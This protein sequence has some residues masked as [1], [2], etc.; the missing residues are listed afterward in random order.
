M[1]IA[2]KIILFVIMSISFLGVVGEK[3]KELRQTMT[4]VCIASMF[5][6][7]AAFIWI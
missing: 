4:G 5:S 2:L 7:V 1:I 6:A 3:D